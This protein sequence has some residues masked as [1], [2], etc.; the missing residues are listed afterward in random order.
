MAAAWSPARRPT[1]R[2]PGCRGPDGREAA[3]HCP[4]EVGLSSPGARPIVITL[5]VRDAGDPV[6][7]STITVTLPNQHKVTVNTNEHGR[8]QLA[9]RFVGSFTATVSARH[10]LPA[11]A[12]FTL[13]G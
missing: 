7:Y 2:A 10:S 9:T 13:P 1:P 3:A 11:T 5:E 8:A 12:K 6:P 4:L